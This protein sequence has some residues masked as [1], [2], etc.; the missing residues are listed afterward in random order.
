M[1]DA[2]M[3]VTE[4]SAASHAEVSKLAQTFLIQQ[5]KLAATITNFSS[6]AV[7][8]AASIELPRSGG[9]TVGSKSE[10][11]K[12]DSQIVTWEAD[13]ISL[14]QH[15]VIQFVL[16]DKAAIQSNVATVK[17]AI[18]KATKALALDMDTKIIVELRLASSSAPDHLI[19]FTDTTNED[20][21]LGDILAARKLLIDQNIDPREC[22]MGVG[23]DQEKFMLAIDNFISAEK[24]GSNEPILNG[25]IG[26]IY[27][28]KVIVHTGF[29]QEALFWHPSAVGFAIQQGTR[30]Q[31]ESALSDLGTR[32]S[33]DYIAGFEVLDGGVRQVQISE[34]A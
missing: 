14:D 30:F 4:T 19:K 7:P 22:F 33:L 26:K 21:E 34:T 17:D 8:G 11:T 24:Y 9:F 2:L 5:A 10:N 12:V 23:S 28:M 31:T 27:G 32:Y 13:T 25:E 18:M 1:A 20:I 15:R 3:G 29:N 16:E 6:L